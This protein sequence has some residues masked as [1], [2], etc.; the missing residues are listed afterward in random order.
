[1][2]VD[3]YVGTGSLEKLEK[4]EHQAVHA[5]RIHQAWR[6][7]V[8]AIAVRDRAASSTPRRQ[9]CEIDAWLALELDPSFRTL[10]LYEQ[11]VEAHEDFHRALEALY[12]DRSS[13]TREVVT[14][15]TVLKDCLEDWLTLAR[16]RSR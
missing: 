5:L 11:T 10:P 12:A 13:S 8:R 3:V 9:A 7:T 16:H 14:A 2:S 6:A 1:M 15:A 4:L